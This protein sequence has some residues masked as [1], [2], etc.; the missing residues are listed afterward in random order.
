MSSSQRI[1]ADL[2]SFGEAPIRLDEILQADGEEGLRRFYE[3]SLVRR[4][5]FELEFPELAAF[6]RERRT[7]NPLPRQGSLDAVD[8][9]FVRIAVSKFPTSDDRPVYGARAPIFVAPLCVLPVLKARYAERYRFAA[10]LTW[11]EWQDWRSRHAEPNPYLFRHPRQS[12]RIFVPPYD[13]LFSTVL[14]EPIPPSL[15]G[16]EFWIV[17]LA[18]AHGGLSGNIRYELWRWDGREAKFEKLF[19][20]LDA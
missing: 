8:R 4:R 18:V 10:F 14:N 6:V 1:F 15:G 11:D 13:G 7:A 12:W 9:E 16:V 19:G 17:E 20:F 2:L 3:S 5:E